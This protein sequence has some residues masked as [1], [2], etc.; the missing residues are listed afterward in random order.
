MEVIRGLGVPSVNDRQLRI[1]SSL[2]SEMALQGNT[3]LLY[4]DPT[5]NHELPE[6]YNG[7]G[8]KNL[9]YMAIQISHFHLQWIN[10]EEKTSTLPNHIY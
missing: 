5:L 8:F 10:T 6:A 4:I 2:S 1:I 7:L 9:I 3:S